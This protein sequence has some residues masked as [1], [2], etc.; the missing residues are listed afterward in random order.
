MPINLLK[1]AYAAGQIHIHLTLDIALVEHID[2]VENFT[3]H[4]MFQ[5]LDL[6][7]LMTNEF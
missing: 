7:Q 6:L 4:N 5:S 1:S 2:I 3:L